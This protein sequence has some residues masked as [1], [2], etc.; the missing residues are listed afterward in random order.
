MGEVTNYK[1]KDKDSKLV[2]GY[3]VC[4][5]S[6]KYTEDDLNILSILGSYYIKPNEVIL[7]KNYIVACYKK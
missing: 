2:I 5:N 6:P 3:I 7:N 4:A 1:I